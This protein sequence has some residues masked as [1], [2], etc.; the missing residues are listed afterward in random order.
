MFWM[1]NNKSGEQKHM[2][3]NCLPVHILHNTI[4]EKTLKNDVFMACLAF[5]KFKCL[6]MEHDKHDTLQ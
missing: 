2:V 4:S 5:Q 3:Q 1:F 6:S